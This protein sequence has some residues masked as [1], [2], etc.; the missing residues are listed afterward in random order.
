M[1]FK[2]DKIPLFW[3][4]EIH[5]TKKQTE[6]YGDLIGKYLVEK[7]SNREVIWV[8]PR[9]RGLKYRFR[10]VYLTAGSILTHVHGNCVVWGSGII[11]REYKINKA[12]FLAVRGPQSRKLLLEQ[13]Y[14]VPEIY[15]DPALLL[16]RFYKPVVPKV[17]KMGIIPHY[18]DYNFVVEQYQNQ[19]DILIIDLMT[20]DV[21]TVTN[22]IISCLTIV[23]S[24]LH[25]II[26]S[27]AYYIPAVWVQFSNKIFG[28]GVKYQDYYESVGLVC[29]E[30]L[31]LSEL[32]SKNQLLTL[33]ENV[34]LPN[35]D[36]LKMMQDQLMECC[37]FNN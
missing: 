14:N 9:R 32:I 27:H 26:V 15:G 8:H 11:S 21:E 23:S 20:N 1:M 28:D 37:P 33:F 36:T 3:W 4:S 29:P 2:R 24:S 25:G 16:P 12:V 22:L 10:K 18:V 5:L 34:M 35:P 6:N 7:I 19:P 31:F 30:P 17:Y 13:G